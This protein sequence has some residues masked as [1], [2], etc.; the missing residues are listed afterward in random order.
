MFPNTEE[1]IKSLFGDIVS[2]V[3]KCCNMAKS[4]QKVTSTNTDFKDSA[5]T[6]TEKAKEILMMLEEEF[7]NKYTGGVKENIIQKFAN[8]SKCGYICISH[9]LWAIHF[10]ITTL[11]AIKYFIKGM[12]QACREYT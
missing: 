7:T 9:Q 1:K 3:N 4:F 10:E 11:A 2:S 8:I 6:T 5:K 12:E